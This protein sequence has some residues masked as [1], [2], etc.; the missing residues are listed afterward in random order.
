MWIN[1]SLRF[2]LIFSLWLLVSNTF[3]KSAY[4]LFFMSFEKSLVNILSLLF[5]KIKICDSCC[6]V[7]YMFWILI[8]HQINNG[9]IFHIPLHFQCVDCFLKYKQMNILCSFLN[10]ACLHCLCVWYSIIVKWDVF[11]ISLHAV[12]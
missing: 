6:W 1:I 7:H 4:W 8:T 11:T 5:F 9:E 2:S 10:L 3:F 12:F